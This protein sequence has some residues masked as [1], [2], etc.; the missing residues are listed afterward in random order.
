MVHPDEGATVHSS[1]EE[2]IQQIPLSER[3]LNTYDHQ[4]IIDFV[5]HSPTEPKVQQI[6]PTKRR[7]LA[8]ISINNLENDVINLF[9]NHLD[10][11]FTHAILFR[12]ELYVPQI[13]E[14]V[15][16]T[17]R[18][19]AFKLVK[20]NTLLEDVSDT[21]RQQEIIKNYHEG[22]CNH[23]GIS[24][25]ETRIRRSYYWPKLGI[26]TIFY[27]NSCEICQTNKYDRNPPKQKLMI[28]PTPS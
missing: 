19:S 4:I 13:C 5:L 26:D 25:T 22:K 21:E 23:R 24:E 27:I 9:K 18:N 20:C 12:N 2:P 8:Q 3:A 6:F 17:F 1:H 28:T 11:N 14:I 15:R 16:K 10:P 7:L